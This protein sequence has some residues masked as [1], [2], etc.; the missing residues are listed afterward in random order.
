MTPQARQALQRETAFLSGVGTKLE[1]VKGKLL[2]GTIWRRSEHDEIDRL[3][4]L[5]AEAGV[6]D[7][8]KR[9]EL[10]GNRRVSLH[11]FERRWWFGKRRT[12]VA[13]ASVLSPLA[14][15][16]EGSS[17]AA[18]PISLGMLAAHVRKIVGT[19]DVPH[20]VGV[21]SPSGVCR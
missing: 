4:A 7:R 9:K 10:P 3:I 18:P 20:V 8:E 2:R 6:H 21:C 13:T 11:G 15:Y 1:S 14:H 12:G 17:A 5:M 16:V 19:A